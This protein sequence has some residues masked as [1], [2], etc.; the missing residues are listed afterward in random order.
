MS[1]MKNKMKQKKIVIIKVKQ[2]NNLNKQ[3]HS[4]KYNLKIKSFCFHLI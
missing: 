1:Q 3:K 4:T 2:M